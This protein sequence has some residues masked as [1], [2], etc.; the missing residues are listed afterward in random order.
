[1][2]SDKERAVVPRVS[3][4]PGRFCKHGIAHFAAVGRYAGRKRG[5]AHFVAVGRYAAMPDGQAPWVK[6]D[7]AICSGMLFLACQLAARSRRR[8]AQNDAHGHGRGFYALRPPL[9]SWPRLLL[10]SP[11]P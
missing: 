6:A 5:F 9:C 3:F 8:A 7:V 10:H 11:V 2:P 1:M 4:D